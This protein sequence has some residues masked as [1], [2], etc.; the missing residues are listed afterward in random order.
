M[1]A[2][3]TIVV[4][5]PVAGGLDLGASAIA[6]AAPAVTEAVTPTDEP[7]TPEPP[8]APPPAAAAS[9]SVEK[10]DLNLAYHRL[11]AAQESMRLLHGQASHLAWLQRRVTDLLA[12]AVATIGT[13]EGGLCQARLEGDALSIDCDRV[14]LRDAIQNADGDLAIFLRKLV[15]LTAPD[16][17]LEIA[18]LPD[19]PPVIARL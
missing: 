19:T 17:G 14:P 9:R 15:T 13:G 2:E 5:Q 8:A 18:I 16:Q 6:I 10:A 1:A 7:V 4:S 12:S 11:R 3:R